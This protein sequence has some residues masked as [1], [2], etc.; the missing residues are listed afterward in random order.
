MMQTVE[1]GKTLLIDGPACVQVI[2]GELSV[3]GA[4]VKVGDKVIVRKGKRMP[5]E[6]LDGAQVELTL[7]DSASY[8]EIDGSA[9][10]SSWKEAVNEILSTKEQKIILVMGGIDSGK[11]S[12]CTYLINRALDVKYEVALIDGDLGQ[13]DIG[14]PGTVGLGF[15]RKPVVDLFNLQPEDIIFIGV[16]S[17][18]RMTNATLDAL[19]TLKAEALEMGTDFLIVNTDGWI[20]GDDAVNYKVRLVKAVAPNVVLVIQSG[21]EL[22]PIVDALKDVKF[23]AINSPKNVKRRDRETRKNLRESAYRKYLRGAKFR[24]CPL[25]WVKMEGNLEISAKNE[26][27]LRN[28]IEDLL[29]KKIVYCRETPNCIL[30]VLEKGI[31]LKEE[32]MKKLESGFDKRLIAIREGDEQGLL[33]A[34]EDARGKFLGIGTICNVDFEKGVMKICTPQ[35]G[36]VSKIHVGQIRLDREGKELT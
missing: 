6:A 7:G 12:L 16:T 30:L 4:L 18:S 15:V 34:L 31:D 26:Y 35:N 28:K 13:S 25:S 22:N 1:K 36:T 33:V 27:Q 20:E 9:I 3:F 19:V 23:L 2:S 32:E 21:N 14:P 10:P 24:L 8:V 17:P 5:F 29:G 11:T